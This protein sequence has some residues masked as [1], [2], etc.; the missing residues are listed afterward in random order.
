M[1]HGTGFL[2]SEDKDLSGKIQPALLLFVL[3]V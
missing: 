1:I 3:Q 2:D